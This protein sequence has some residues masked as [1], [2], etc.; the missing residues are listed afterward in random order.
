M[1]FTEEIHKY[2]NLELITNYI[3]TLIIITCLIHIFNY[4]FPSL[5]TFINN[6]IGVFSY[7]TNNLYVSQYESLLLEIRD[8]EIIWGF[9]INKIQ[10]SLTK[11][12]D[13]EIKS[14]NDSLDHLQS[15]QELLEL[16]IKKLHYKQKK[17]YPMNKK[18]PDSAFYSFSNT[19]FEPLQWVDPS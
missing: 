19:N 6:I 14:L 5:N 17:M 1:Y 16:T 15:K 11:K 18:S 13:E 12:Y 7:E 4:I 3:V 10:T 9:K 2:I 8:L